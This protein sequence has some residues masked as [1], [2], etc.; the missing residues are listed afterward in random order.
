MAK[1]RGEKG[2]AGRGSQK[3]VWNALAE[4]W[5]NFRQKPFPD[6]EK[7][8]DKFA[9]GWAP[10][11]ILDIGCGNCRNLAPFAEN[12]FECYGID[13]SLAMLDWA[14]EYLQKRKLKATLRRANATELPFPDE[15]FDYALSIAVLHH[16]ETGDERQQAVLEIKRVL[17]PGGKAI[18][19]VWNKL[20]SRFFFKQKDLLI[21]WKLKGNK[22][23]RFYHLFTALEL[24]RLLSNAGFRVLR[25]NLFG[26]NLIF[27]VQKPQKAL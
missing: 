24:R 23:D 11:K 26:R 25:G 27:E 21:P 16:L 20:Q 18:V 4:Q 2:K 22:Y 9:K 12:K 14:K 1:K 7:K 3:E 17:K 13:F 6:V 15:F 8:L 10:G 19:A 5:H